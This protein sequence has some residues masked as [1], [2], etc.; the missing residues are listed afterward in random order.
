MQSGVG[1]AEV[2]ARQSSFPFTLCDSRI[3]FIIAWAI[4]ALI[5]NHLYLKE[6]SPLN[7]SGRMQ[8]SK[9]DPEMVDSTCQNH[10]P[11]RHVESWHQNC[12]IFFLLNAWHFRSV[13]S[14][15]INPFEFGLYTQHNF[16][17]STL[18]LYLQLVSSFYW[19]AF[20]GR[21]IGNLFNHSPI[22]KIRVGSSLQLL[23]TRLLC[24]TL[25]DCLHGHK[26][27]SGLQV[28]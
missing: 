23:G 13:W 11:S 1:T 22:E 18:L 25:Q 14:H 10:G 8:K 21:D 2:Q 12:V 27:W 3:W 15:L 28:Q 5:Q 26:F 20:H 16:L 7:H 4:L 17:V 9:S 24:T 6:K 19:L